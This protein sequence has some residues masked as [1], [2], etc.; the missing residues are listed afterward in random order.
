M[1]V[2]LFSSSVVGRELD[3]FLA[4]FRDSRASAFEDLHT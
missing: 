2:Q 4:V 3:G 1:V